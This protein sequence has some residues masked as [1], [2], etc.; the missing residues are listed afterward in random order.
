L[1]EAVLG[2]SAGSVV[3]E[4]ME[5]IATVIVGGQAGLATTYHL[6]A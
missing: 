2:L 4:S 1:R 6:A 5:R 3:T